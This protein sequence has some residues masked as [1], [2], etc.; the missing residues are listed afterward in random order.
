MKTSSLRILALVATIAPVLAL[1][2]TAAS[3]ATVT[4]MVGP[5]CLCFMPASV[6]IHPGDTV[7]WIWSS[8]GHSSTSGTPG[9]PNGLWDSGI[10]NQGAMFTHTFNSVGSFPYYCTPHGACCHRVGMVTVSNPTTTP[11]PTPRP[12]A[13]PTATATPRPTSTPS[14]TPRPTTTPT[15]TPASTPAVSDFNRDGHPDYLLFN[16]TNRATVIW[17]MNNNVHIGGAAGPTLLA[18]WSVGAVAD[19]N[20]DGHPDY[21]LF[22]PNTGGTVIWYMNNNVRIGAVSGPT[23]PGGW[24]LVGAADFNNDGHPDY[25]LFNSTNR[26]TVIWYMNNN[27][28]VGGAA[29]PTLPGGWSVVAP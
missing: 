2:P 4:V 20:L 19:F 21:L 27:V 16:S 6:T 10:L 28:H 24:T 26:A 23:L 15:A 22:N 1:Y 12:T 7:Q 5:N 17:Y 8:T 11:T 14:P 25:L 18:G 29:G 3:A 9:M 13:T